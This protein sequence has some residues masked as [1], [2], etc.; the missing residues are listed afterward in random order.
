MLLPHIKLFVKINRGLELLPLLNFLHNFWRKY[1]SCYSCC[2]PFIDQVSLSGCLCFLRYLAICLLGCDNMDFEVKLS[3]LIE[4]FF[5]HGLKVNL[6]IL[7]KLKLVS[8]IFYQIFI[9]SS[10]DRFSKTMES[11]Y[12]FI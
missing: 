11:V 5:L 8:A 7:V 12:Y 9:F 3:L 10:N 6:N 2:I 4:M 1:F